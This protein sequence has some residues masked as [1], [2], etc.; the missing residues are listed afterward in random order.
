MFALSRPFRHALVL[1]AAC[2]LAA[3]GDDKPKSAESAPSAKSQAAAAEQA[4]VLKY[5]QYVDTANGVSTSFSEALERYNKYNTPAVNAKKP[6]KDFTIQNDIY[7]DR[8]K[9]GLEKAL[10]MQPAM[11]ALDSPAKPFADALGKLSPLSHELQNYSAS[12]GYLAD[13]G[14]KARELSAAYVAALTEVVKQEDAF[15]SGLSDQDM[16]NTKTAFENAKKDSAAYYRIGLVYWG[17][18]AQAQA[19][20]FLAG[21]GLGEHVQ[22]FKDA[23]SQVNDMGQGY[24]RKAREQ[25]QKGCP[26]LMMH[27]NQYVAD[28]RTIIKSTED[29]SY[30]NDAK[31]R[32]AVMQHMSRER[33]NIRDLR[34]HFNNIV[35]ALNTNAC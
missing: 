26:S 22:G 16:Q 27:V 33:D 19:S 13:D 10:A 28:G 35:S 25:N 30:V 9:A 20:T 1:A 15:Y 4:Q 31:N 34:Q 5:N 2:V 12:K 6:I 24:D 32:P 3:C 7:I 8:T 18:A 21:E 17:K 23:I 29:G 14:A 11:P